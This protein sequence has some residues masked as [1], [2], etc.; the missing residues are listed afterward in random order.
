MHEAVRPHMG[1]F[2][3]LPTNPPAGWTETII[4]PWIAHVACYVPREANQ[5]VEEFMLLAN[6]AVAKTVAA[7]FPDRGLLRRHP[8]PQQRT[9]VAATNYV[10]SM[11]RYF[12]SFEV[13][14]ATFW[15]KSR[16]KNSNL[17]MRRLNPLVLE[18]VG[19]RMQRVLRA[20]TMN[21]FI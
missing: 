15:L 17:Q 20:N 11:V 5:L 21:I 1:Q 3:R 10:K 9:L 7:A 13:L 6:M 19:L 2:L 18:S 16:G 12:V 8:P 14:P 4:Q